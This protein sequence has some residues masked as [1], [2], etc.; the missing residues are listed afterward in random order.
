MHENYPIKT[1]IQRNGY[2]N[3]DRMTFNFHGKGDFRLVF[4]CGTKVK[5]NL[6]KGPLFEDTTGL[7]DWVAEDR[8]I[9]KFTAMNDGIDSLESSIN[10]SLPIAWVFNQGDW[11]T[12]HLVFRHLKLSLIKN[13]NYNRSGK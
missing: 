9:V 10:H 2:K 6:G 3:E 7:L 11:K 12:A 5:D 8:A 4:H 13:S 1:I